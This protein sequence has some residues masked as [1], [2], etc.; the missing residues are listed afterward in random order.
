V[1]RRAYS[2]VQMAII[3]TGAHGKWESTRRRSHTIASKARN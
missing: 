1:R 3:E 2:L